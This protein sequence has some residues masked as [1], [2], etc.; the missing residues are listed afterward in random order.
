MKTSKTASG[1]RNDST[2]KK[3]SEKRKARI[4][5]SPTEEQ[6]RKKAEEIFLMRTAK[7]QAGDALQDWLEAETLLHNE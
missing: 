7:G 4:K 5:S 3:T 2:P 6:I 1:S